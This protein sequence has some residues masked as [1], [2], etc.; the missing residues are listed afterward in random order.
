M[1]VQ[2]LDSNSNLKDISSLYLKSDDNQDALSSFN[3]KFMIDENKD[4]KKNAIYDLP[5]LPVLPRTVDMDFELEQVPSNNYLLLDRAESRML[6]KTG[7]SIREDNLLSFDA[8]KNN[9]PSSSSVTQ[10]GFVNKKSDQFTSSRNMVHEGVDFSSVKPKSANMHGVNVNLSLIKTLSQNKA[11]Q[12]YHNNQSSYNDINS[13]NRISP[14]R[15]RPRSSIHLSKSKNLL[16]NIFNPADVDSDYGIS[17]FRSISKGL[18]SNGVNSYLAS[19]P[20]STVD[21]FSINRPKSTVELENKINKIKSISLDSSRKNSSLMTNYNYLN[22]GYLTNK[23]TSPLLLTTKN[24]AR[25]RIEEFYRVLP[26]DKKIIKQHKSKQKSYNMFKDIKINTIQP[27]EPKMYL[28]EKLKKHMIVFHNN[29]GKSFQ[30]SHVN[31]VK[32]KFSL[33]SFKTKDG[34]LFGECYKDILAYKNDNDFSGR[35]KA[36]LQNMLNILFLEEGQKDYTSVN[37][38][39]IYEIDSG[40]LQAMSRRY[41]RN[42]ELIAESERK[43]VMSEDEDA[44]LSALKNILFLKKHQKRCSTATIERDL[45][46]KSLVNMSNKEFTLNIAATAKDLKAEKSLKLKTTKS[47]KEKPQIR[48]KKTSK[49]KTSKKIQKEVKPSAMK[50][51]KPAPFKNKADCNKPNIRS[52]NGCWTCRLRKKKCSEEKDECVN[53]LRMQVPCDYNADKPAYMATAELKRLKVLEI[54]RISVTNKQT[55]KKAKAQDT[56]RE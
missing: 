15:L 33:N 55:S 34:V 43:L 18:R 17:N 39:K 47:I 31:T 7:T 24:I 28:D 41:K 45:Q 20:P 1:S 6:T 5:S 29:L 53:C 22:G 26:R 32:R 8:Y 50:S 13:P 12:G 16:S 4:V 21:D 46:T 36:K 27:L 51:V 52:K 37:G 35:D 48:K 38:Q 54:K 3:R 25:T 2:E 14:E 23:G 10:L 30:P 44:N 56:K 9:I 11:K 42:G 40:K 19:S 49:P